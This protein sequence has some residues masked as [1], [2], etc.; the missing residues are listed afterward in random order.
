MSGTVT[1]PAQSRKNSSDKAS[2]E[3]FALSEDGSG[4]EDIERRSRCQSFPQCSLDSLYLE[5]GFVSKE[6]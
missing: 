2:F 1:G 6:Q 5:I 3:D 4:D